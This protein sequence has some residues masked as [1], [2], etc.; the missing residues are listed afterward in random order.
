MADINS[1]KILQ[2]ERERLYI[3]NVGDRPNAMNSYQKTKMSAQDV[4]KLFDD[5][6]DFLAD[7]HNVLYDEVIGAEGER[8][9]MEDARA[10]NELFRQAQEKLRILNEYGNADYRLDIDTGLIVDK[11]GNPVAEEALGGRQGAERQR[12]LQEEARELQERQRNANEYGN[13]DYNWNSDLNAVVDADGN[14]VPAEDIGGRHGEFGDLAEAVD[15]IHKIT[16]EILNNIPTD[17][18][19]NLISAVTDLEKDVRSVESDIS[20]LD[21]SIAEVNKKADDNSKQIERVSGRTDIAEQDIDKIKKNLD[22]IDDF[23]GMSEQFDNNDLLNRTYPIGSIYMSVNSTDPASLFGGSW[24]RLQDRFLI[25]AGSTYANGVTGGSNGSHSHGAGT[26]RALFGG[27]SNASN[28]FHYKTTAAAGSWAPNK[29]ITTSSGTN[30][31]ISLRYT[32]IA[33]DGSTES[34]IDMP[35]Y[36]AVYMWKRTA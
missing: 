24:V 29:M 3:R 31:D 25:G 19:A 26:L 36:L 5:Q 34:T 12:N 21:E 18:V 10:K 1:A 2:S 23:L 13:P 7:K 6:F 35:P 27:D 32:G 33:I 20:G 8:Q 15:D 28:K 17:P 4:K 14:P 22:D 30:S 11:N 9:E 16:D